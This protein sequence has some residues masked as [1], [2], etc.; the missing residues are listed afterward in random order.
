MNDLST[1]IIGCGWLGKAFGESLAQKGNSVYGSV[2][3]ESG[4][5]SLSQLGIRPFE[6]DLQESVSVPN[7]ICAS[8]R[9]LVITLPP[10]HRDEPMR[11]HDKLIA[12]LGQ[13]SDDVRVIFTS[14]TGIYPDKEG[15]YDESFVFPDDQDSSI[16]NVAENAIRENANSHVILRLGGLIG[17]NRHPI[18]YLQGRSEVKN[19]FGIINFVHQ[20]DCVRAM[21]SMIENKETTGTFNL[22]FPDYPQRKDYYTSAAHHYD[23]QAPTFSDE[24]PNKRVI[25]SQKITQQLDFEFKFP[26]D[27]FPELKF[28]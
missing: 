28:D 11:Y 13:F 12:L 5:S 20:G 22:V 19:P 25:S 6:L 9:S 2:R 24:A 4:F 26:I 16:L 15:V 27:H 10:L 23:L 7:E 18:R 21:L 3:N 17:P 1:T 14:S 8:T